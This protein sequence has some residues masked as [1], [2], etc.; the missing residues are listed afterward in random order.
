METLILQARNKRES[1]LIKEL[2]NKMNISVTTLSKEEQEDFIFGKLIKE[3]VKEG[4]AKH[5]TIDKI[6]KKWK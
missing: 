2:M 3:A 6:L 4:E 5:A 1:L